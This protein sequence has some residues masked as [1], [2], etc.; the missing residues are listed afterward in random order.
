MLHEMR[1]F[2]NV[3]LSVPGE[4]RVAKTSGTTPHP[5]RREQEEQR[6]NRETQG[7]QLHIAGI[8][9]VTLEV[10]LHEAG[11]SG[12][13]VLWSSIGLTVFFWGIAL[14]FRRFSL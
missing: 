3:S 6:L 9:I 11:I 14:F 4:S 8:G 13:L 12:S 5:T 10:A 2:V 1:A 7:I